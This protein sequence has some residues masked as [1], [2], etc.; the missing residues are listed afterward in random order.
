M[1][2]VTAEQQA[3]LRLVHWFF[4]SRLCLAASELL[5]ETRMWEVFRSSERRDA[6]VLGEESMWKAVL[7]SADGGSMLHELERVRSECEPLLRWRVTKRSGPL[8]EMRNIVSEMV[9]RGTEL[10]ARGVP[11]AVGA[12]ETTMRLRGLKASLELLL[13]LEGGRGVAKW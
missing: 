12:V 3:R 4:S 10:E 6:A 9:V 13:E 5:G 7:G 1:P 2:P 8:D 11:N